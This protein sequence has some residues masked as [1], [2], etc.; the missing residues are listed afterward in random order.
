M[1]GNCFISKPSVQFTRADYNYSLLYITA[2]FGPCFFA[3]LRPMKLSTFSGHVDVLWDVKLNSVLTPP[4]QPQT[5]ESISPWNLADWQAGLLFHWKPF[6]R[7]NDALNILFLGKVWGLRESVLF[8]P[9]S[10]WKLGQ[11][12][13]PWR[14]PRLCWSVLLF[15]WGI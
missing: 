7:N 1:A 3:S 5:P 11:L 13:L 8:V 15:L 4:P 10:L 14:C 6:H 12:L 9:Q 2:P